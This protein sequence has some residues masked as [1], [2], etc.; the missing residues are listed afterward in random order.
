LDAGKVWFE[1]SAERGFG[2]KFFA[3]DMP[4]VEPQKGSALP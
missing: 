1:G 2:L 4:W 3:R